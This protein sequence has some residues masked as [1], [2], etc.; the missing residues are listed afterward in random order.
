MMSEHQGV[1]DQVK[2]RMKLPP[3]DKPSEDEPRTLGDV[4]NLRRKTRE[5]VERKLA[6][7]N[8]RSQHR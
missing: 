4:I 1:P 2:R 5:E 3:Y 7:R 8:H 6:L